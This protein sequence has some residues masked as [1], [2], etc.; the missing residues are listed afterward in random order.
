MYNHKFQSTSFLVKNHFRMYYTVSTF[1]DFMNDEI[2]PSW[3]GMTLDDRGPLVSS[4]PSPLS[5]MLTSLHFAW[6]NT[7]ESLTCMGLLQV[8]MLGR[9]DADSISNGKVF[10]IS[11]KL[12]LML[13]W[14]HKEIQDALYSI[15]EH[16][17]WSDW[18]TPGLLRGGFPWRF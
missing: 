9:S 8:V 7:C 3:N 4:L 14:T 6:F 2:Y 10:W 5:K 17:A 18:H 12:L 11:N 15:V 1:H 13:L 16:V